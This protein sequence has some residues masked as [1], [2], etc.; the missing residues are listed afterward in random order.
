MNAPV[1]RQNRSERVCE[2]LLRLAAGEALT[3]EQAGRRLYAQFGE[4]PAALL[5]AL[6]V[7]QRRRLTQGLR[8]RGCLTLAEWM[9]K[10]WNGNGGQS[11]DCDERRRGQLGGGGD[12]AGAGL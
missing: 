10:E 1:Y 9:E 6:S 2:A 5:V 7:E 4:P 12:D 8:R 3:P 11:V